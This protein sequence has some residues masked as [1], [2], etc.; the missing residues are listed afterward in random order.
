MT[1]LQASDG[2]DALSCRRLGLFYRVLIKSKT[3]TLIVSFR[4]WCLGL[5]TG[6]NPL[7]H[8]V[9]GAIQTKL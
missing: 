5:G 9:P 7:F 2:K 1:S 4:R 3:H 6:G 8:L